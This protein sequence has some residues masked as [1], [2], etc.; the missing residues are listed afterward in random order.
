VHPPAA[1]SIPIGRFVALLEVPQGTITGVG[2]IAVV[3]LIL[4]SAFFASAGIAILSLG[5][6]RIGAP[7]DEGVPG[8]ATLSALRSDPRRCW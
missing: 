1:A 5:D 7:V 6:H 8:A 2:I 3:V 4:F